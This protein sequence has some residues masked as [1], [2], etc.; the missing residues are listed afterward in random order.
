M[1]NKKLDKLVEQAKQEMENASNSNSWEHTA[2]GAPTLGRLATLQIEVT[3]ELTKTIRK[4]DEKNSKLQRL[5]AI[6]AI[7]AAIEPTR[8]LIKQLLRIL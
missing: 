4:L 5:V 2:H 3:V 8:E 1:N 6:V 7:V